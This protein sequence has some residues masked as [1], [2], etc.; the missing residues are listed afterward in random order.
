MLPSKALV[1]NYVSVSRTPRQQTMP[2]VSPGSENRATDCSLYSG[3]NAAPS[4]DLCRRS[5]EQAARPQNQTSRRPGAV[6]LETGPLN[7]DPSRAALIGRLLRKCCY[8]LLELIPQLQTGTEVQ[9]TMPTLE[10]ACNSC[11]SGCSRALDCGPCARSHPGLAGHHRLDDFFDD[12]L[13]GN[14][15]IAGIEALSSACMPWSVSTS[16]R[17]TIHLA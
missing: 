8:S 11:H 10:K 5:P 2:S 13:V 14:G 12:R 17:W 16:I 4:V 9:C 1:F 3:K 6:E 15:D 7:S